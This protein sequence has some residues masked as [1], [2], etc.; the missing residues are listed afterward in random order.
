MSILVRSREFLKEVQ[1]EST[2]VSWPTRN[3]LRDSTIVVIVTVLI[4][5]VFIG[6]VD[7]LLTF[8]IG[9]LFKLFR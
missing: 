8:G 4:V 7:R 9:A 5:S 3:E 1:V 6:V 2:K